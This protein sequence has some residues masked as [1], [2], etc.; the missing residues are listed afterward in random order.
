MVEEL[1]VPLAAWRIFDECG[2]IPGWLRTKA[3]LAIETGYNSGIY[4]GC[5]TFQDCVEARAKRFLGYGFD[6]QDDGRLAVKTEGD[7]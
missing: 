5:K 7:Q 1:G 2:E 6:V 4:A 3:D